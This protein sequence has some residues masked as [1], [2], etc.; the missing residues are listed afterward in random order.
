MTTPMDVIQ[1]SEDSSS[2]LSSQ[3][4]NSLFQEIEQLM[5]QCQDIHLHHLTAIQSLYSI[6]Q[7]LSSQSKILCTYQQQEPRDFDSILEELHTQV[8]NDINEG[9]SV[10]FSQLLLNA[11]D[12]MTFS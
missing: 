8:M 4:D 1:E 6:Q 9:K 12:Q 10:N 3:E 7:L 2:D 5:E 11:M